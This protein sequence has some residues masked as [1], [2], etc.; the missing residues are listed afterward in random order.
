MKDG[1]GVQLKVVHTRCVGLACTGWS[2]LG[3]AHA[4]IATSLV[5]CSSSLANRLLAIFFCSHIGCMTVKEL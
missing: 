2:R 4:S 1:G 5:K 3:Y